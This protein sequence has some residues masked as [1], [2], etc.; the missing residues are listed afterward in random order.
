LRFSTGGYLLS[1][2]GKSIWRNKLTSFLSCATTA[3][4]LFL[5]GVAFLV[6]LNIKFTYAV[7]QDQMEIQAY[8]A[9]ETTLDQAQAVYEAIKKLPGVSHAEYVSKEEALE[10]LKQRFQDNASVLAGLGDDNPLPASVRLKVDDVAETSSVVAEIKKMPQ[11]EDVIYQEGTSRQLASLGIATQYVSLGG[12]LIVGLVAIMVIGNSIRLTID[13]RRHEIGIMKL[14]G[15][16]DEFI[17]GPF[18]LEGMILGMLGG[19][20]GEGLVVG[21]YVWVVRGVQNVVPFLPVME[22]TMPV[23]LDMLGIMLVTGMAVGTIGSVLALR[24]HLRV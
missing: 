13:A 24:K 14:V 2:T 18:L 11:V 8:L 4:S 3:L 15:A 1:E 6:S 10:W 17:I 19:L 20:I 16:T 21:L 9:K 23:A 12:M 22:L 5:L 7:V